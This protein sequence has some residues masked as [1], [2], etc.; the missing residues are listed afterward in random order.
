LKTRELSPAKEIPMKS[1]LQRM[2][3]A[4]S[5]AALAA[6]GLLSPLA[7]AG[8]TEIAQEPL[9]VSF[10]TP[11]KP[12]LLFILDDSGSM[13]EIYLPEAANRGADKYSVRTPQCNGLAFKEGDTYVPAVNHDGSSKA[14]GVIGNNFNAS[15]VLE[16]IRNLAEDNTVM[17]NNAALE[18][19]VSDGGRQA[20][21]YSVGEPVTVYNGSSVKKWMIGYVVSW[22][23][24]TGKLKVNFID[25]SSAAD[26]TGTSAKVGRG[27]PHF[28]YFSYKGA[29][30]PIDWTYSSTGSIVTTTDFYKECNSRVNVAPGSGVFER[31]IMRATDGGAQNFA[32]WW[33][34]YGNR[35]KMM[36]TVS[37]SAFLGID[38]SF[39]V[40]FSRISTTEAKESGTKWLHVRDFEGGVGSQREKFYTALHGTN[41]SGYTPLRGALS[42]AGRYIANKAVAQ[43]VDPVQFSCQKHFAILATDGA[44]NNNMETATFGP[45]DLA[46]ATVGQRDGAVARPM[47]DTKDDGSGGASNTLADVAIYFYDTDLRTAAL[48]NCSG[49]G[50]KDVCANNVPVV[51]GSRDSAKHQHLTTFTMSLGQNG[52]LKFCTGY[53]TGCQG[54]LTTDYP[55]LVAGTK[56]WPAPSNDASKVDDLWHAAVNGRGTFF[57]ASDAN[58]VADGLKKALSEIEKVVG[59]GAA[60]ATSTTQ[61]VANDNSFFIASFTSGS[62]HGDLKAHTIDPATFE[63]KMDAAVWSAAE[64]LPAPAARKILYANA[65]ALREFTSA[66]LVA[67][68]LG[69]QFQ[70]R[71]ASMSHY[72]ALAVADRAECDKAEN[73]VSFLRGQDFAYY[74]ARA[75]ESKLGDIVG[76]APV[77]DGKNGAS[78]TDAG[79]AAFVTATRKTRT[80]MVYVGGNDGMLHAFD[81]ATGVEQWAF[82]PSAVRSRLWAL[83]DKSYSSKHEFFVDGPP[84]TE[85]VFDGAGWRTIL[86]SGLGAGGRAYV[87]LDV[88]DPAT[89]KLLWEF[90]NANLGYTFAKPVVAKRGDGTWVVV[91]P[92][93]FNNV[94][95]GQGRL[96]MLNAVTGAVLEN[97]STGEGTAAEPAGLGPVTPWIDDGN[98]DATAL[99]YYAGDNLGNVWRFD[100]DG[101]LV[102]ASSKVIKLAALQKDGKAQPVTVPP[103]LGLMRVAG[104]ETPVVAVGTGRMVGKSDLEN[105]DVQSVYAIKDEL[106]EGWGD[107]RAGGKLVAQEIVTDA[108]VRKGTAMSVE[109]KTKAGWVADLPDSGERIN[110]PM[111]LFGSTLV[112][113]SNVPESIAGCEEGSQGHAWIYYFDM[114]TGGVV[115]DYLGDSM[116]AGLN[117][118]GRGVLPVPSIASKNIKYREVRQPTGTATTPRR[119]NWREVIDR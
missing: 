26:N 18:L 29:Q 14:V 13:G 97:L 23:K 33:T 3:T 59:R 98:T 109:W 47:R 51:E 101:L 41:P 31:K 66:N 49:E 43:D 69:A 8:L 34:Y 22:N 72:L 9:L 92:S 89:P 105:T 65:G 37:A 82:I 74:R 110:V 2:P 103:L 21:W 53:E 32:N 83:G 38:A 96:F 77:F 39:R 12:N 78:F 17:V 68:G 119:A 24:D 87:A 10:G 19:T 25:Y 113:A 62:W 48:G 27:W 6:A 93:G 91:V 44:W 64:K 99:R 114:A 81:A 76:S 104:V 75:A 15:D 20:S 7:Q 30:K 4:R 71:C 46:G 116:V 107:I 57:N 36:R 95:D 73:L 42:V 58:G 117:A 70:G 55:A 85:D 50:G 90:T 100:P 63:P 40:G 102:G 56:V 115:A 54:G 60:G 106:G 79:Y 52:T 45:F 108:G 11:V 35:I 61:P 1:F 94:G 112:A 118:V 67:D 88:T 16:N 84:V 111:V 80:P 5:C 86:V 28:V